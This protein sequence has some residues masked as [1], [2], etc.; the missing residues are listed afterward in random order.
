[1]SFTAIDLL[2]GVEQFTVL[3][4]TGLQLQTIQATTETLLF[5]IN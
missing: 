4:T 5:V 1:M 3:I 2:A